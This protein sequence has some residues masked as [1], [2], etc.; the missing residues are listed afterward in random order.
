M[1]SFAPCFTPHSG[2]NFDT[3]VTKSFWSRVSIFKYLQSWRNIHSKLSHWKVEN[4]TTWYNL[5]WNNRWAKDQVQLQKA[6]DTICVCGG[7]GPNGGMNGHSILA[8][9]AVQNGSFCEFL[10]GLGLNFYHGVFIIKTFDI[11]KNTSVML[12]MAKKEFTS[13]PD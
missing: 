11:L 8:F 12:S 13:K 6:S 4:L 10:S 3:T 9:N 1:F 2:A 5:W 7:W